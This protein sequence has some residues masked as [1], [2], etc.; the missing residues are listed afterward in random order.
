MPR[1]ALGILL[2]DLYLLPQ[3]YLSREIIAACF[4]VFFLSFSIGKRIDSLVTKIDEL[5]SGNLNLNFSEKSGDE[6]SLI[7]GKVVRNLR[8]L[9]MK[10]KS[11]AVKVSEA[12][13]ALNDLAGEQSKFASETSLKAEEIA[14]DA[15]NTSISMSHV[16]SGVAEFTSFAQ[17]L[18][19]AS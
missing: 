5:G 17:D 1:G 11:S 13:K 4:V 14:R 3:V 12:S 19:K 15:Q 16:A 8:E 7:E 10:V 9:I 18:S 6:T 2:K